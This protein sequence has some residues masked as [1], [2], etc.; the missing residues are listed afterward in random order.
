M[1]PREEAIAAVARE[2]AT[3][4]DEGSVVTAVLG[5][6]GLDPQG[7]PMAGGFYPWRQDI[8]PGM[9]AEW[10]LDGMAALW[11]RITW[12]GQW[13]AHVVDWDATDNDGPGWRRRGRRTLRARRRERPLPCLRPSAR[14][15]G[16]R[17]G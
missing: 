10:S 12:R 9:V 8:V 7:E 17:G 13:V 5:S 4:Y 1:T 16:R 2:F 3:T 11:T 14:C 15:P 6:V